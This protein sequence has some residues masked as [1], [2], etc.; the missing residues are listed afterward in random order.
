MN[1]HSDAPGS[2]RHALNHYRVPLIVAAAGIA[3]SIGGF[4]LALRGQT[5]GLERDFLAFARLHA[6]I[7]DDKLI[8]GG[9]GEID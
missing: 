7:I 4:M 8:R 9:K 1:A 2:L 3:L 5:G 6:A